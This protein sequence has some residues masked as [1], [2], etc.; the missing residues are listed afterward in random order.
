[1][2]EPRYD[3]FFRGETLENFQIEQ[4]KTQVG[5][6]FKASPEKVEQLFSGK[7]VTLR[8][9]L[10]K[11]TTLKFKQAL[12]K[13]GAKIYIKAAAA[14]NTAPIQTSP[15][16]AAPQVKPAAAQPPH[17][18]IPK[19]VV[20]L[21]ALPVGSDLLAA[22]ERPQQ[23]A[24]APD[25][26]HI[27]LVSSFL[28]PEPITKEAPPPSPDVS[29]LSTAEVGADILEGFHRTE[30]PVSVPDISHISLAEAGE[31]LASLVAEMNQAIDV[32]DVGYITLAERGA[33]IDPSEK[34]APPPAPDVSH[35]RLTD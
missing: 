34:K 22:A 8:K 12:E 3:I 23:N 5:L 11:A 7:V 20:T 27:K 28:Q 2:S 30:I 19:P 1:M 32:P 25:T 15:T 21:T 29:H 13:A 26:S 14:G 35:I 31:D 16:P 9:D 10:D 4:V 17:N 33:D 6:L 18:E 24:S